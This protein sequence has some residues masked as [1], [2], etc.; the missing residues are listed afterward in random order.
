MDVNPPVA[1]SR[2]IACVALWAVSV[3]T[4]PCAGAERWHVGVVATSDY[5]QRGLSQNYADPALLGG[6]TYRFDSGV[7]AGVWGST[8]S[9]SRT[10]LRDA[11][12]RFEVNYLAGYAQPWGEAWEFDV[13]MLHYEYPDSDAPIDYG[14]TE[15]AASVGY[16]G[17]V[18]LTAAASRNATVYT[19]RGPAR[20]I[21]TT[22]W[23]LSGEHPLSARLSWIAGVG[24]LDFRA[25]SIPGYAYFNTGLAARFP[26]LDAELQYVDTAGGERLFGRRLAGPR[27][28]LSL[29]AGF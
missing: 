24:F 19:R 1:H 12:G 17:R 23:E 4:Q 6:A 26:W 16:R 10:A 14:H 11:A 20:N 21:S 7:Y 28:V 18:R 9:N 25:G 2:A 29:M 3:A 27:V 15:L 5:V 8:V 22:A 13:A